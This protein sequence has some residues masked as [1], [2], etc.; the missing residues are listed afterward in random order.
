MDAALESSRDLLAARK[1][2]SP[3]DT[4]TSRH[5]ETMRRREFIGLLGGAGAMWPLASRAQQSMPTVGFLTSASP[6]TT[7]LRLVPRSL[8][9]FGW[10]ENR[11]YRALYRFAEGHMDRMPALADEL[12]AQ[13]RPNHNETDEV[14]SWLSPLYPFLTET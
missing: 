8:K 1:S 13:R 6:T 3:Q 12:V 4:I 10:E 5:G 9:G 14:S 7:L 11:N 2:A